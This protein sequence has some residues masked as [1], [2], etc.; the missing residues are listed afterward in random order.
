MKIKKTI[1]VP[2]KVIELSHGDRV[3]IY[4]RERDILFE[5]YCEYMMRDKK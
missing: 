4:V 3:S 5:F 2:D 1:E